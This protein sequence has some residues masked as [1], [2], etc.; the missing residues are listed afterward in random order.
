[1]RE[2]LAPPFAEAHVEGNRNDGEAQPFAGLNG[3]NGA[4]VEHSQEKAEGQNGDVHQRNIFQTKTVAEIHEEV[5]PQQ[6]ESRRGKTRGHIAAQ[7][8]QRQKK[9][10]VDDGMRNGDFP[11]GDGTMTLG[12][13]ASILFT[14]PDVVDDVNT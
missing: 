11:G 6:T 1:M 4:A 10:S 13:A 2:K 9:D 14:V 5:G 7:Q 12:G 8:C 3:G